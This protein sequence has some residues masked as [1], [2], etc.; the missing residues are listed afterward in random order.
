M[1]KIDTMLI[2]S[3]PAGELIPYLETG[4]AHS[5]LFLPS[6]MISHF[7][8]ENPSFVL[9]NYGS[10]EQYFCQPLSGDYGNVF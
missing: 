5:A 6:Q 4:L 10:P 7:T 8:R 3:Q 1:T 9:V 2:A